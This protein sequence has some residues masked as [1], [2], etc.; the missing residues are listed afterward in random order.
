[1]A[2]RLRHWSHKPA[3]GVRISLSLPDLGSMM[4]SLVRFQQSPALRLSINGRTHP[5]EPKGL[6]RDRLADKSHGA[7]N[8]GPKGTSGSIPDAATK[9]ATR[10]SETERP[11]RGTSFKVHNLEIPGSTP[12]PATRLR[13]VAPRGAVVAHRSQNRRAVV[14]F[15][16]RV[17]QRGSRESAGLREGD[18]AGD[19]CMRL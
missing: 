13:F 17:A 5:L 14:R 1:M 15:H 11:E 4:R 8:H 6:T 2:E 7:H 9:F 10:G 19:E 12:G 16:P 3:T 18:R